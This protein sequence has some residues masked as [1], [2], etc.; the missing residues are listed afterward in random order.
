[1]NRDLIRQSPE[2]A[3]DNPETMA[4]L[5]KDALQG[6][7]DLY[8]FDKYILDYKDMEIEPHREMCDRVQYGWKTPNN[9]DGK[10]KKLLLEPRGS[11]KSS[12]VTVG[13]SLQNVVL[14]PDI[15]ILIASEKLSNAQKF[16]GEIKGHIERNEY[17]RL[18][19]GIMDSNKDDAVW[20]SNEIVVSTRK[21]NKK[22]PTIST[23][24]VEVTKVGMHY[25][26]IIVDDPVS[27]S[28]VTSKEQIDKVFAWYRLLLSMLDP[29]G[30]LI[31]IGTRWDYGDLYGTLQEYPHCEMFDILIRKAE[32]EET[33]E[34][35]GETE[36]KYLF[37]TRL[38]REFLDETKRSQGTY[39]YSCQYLNEPVADEDATFREEWFK[40]YIE[41]DLRHIDMTKFMTVDPAISLEKA[42]D[43]TA[44]VICGVDRENNIYILHIDRGHY[45][46][47]ELIKKIF[48]Y[49]ARYGLEAVGVEMNVFQ[50]TLKYQIND[51]MRAKKMFI[52]LIELK[53]NKTQAKEDRIRALQPRYEQGTIYHRKN[54]PLIG[55]LE[56]ELLRFPKGKHDDIADAEA[57]LLEIIY[58]PKPYTE[59][60]E[61]DKPKYINKITRW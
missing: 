39:I 25:D 16:L 57:S 38:T 15:R 55:E 11:F 34:K 18:L 9:P 42:A 23:A 26:L 33:N 24:G 41:E 3:L 5:Q 50:K 48:E 49:Y 32:W 40:Y 21:V 61:K 17:F 36:T 8:H 4:L 14:N 59:D 46:P 30:R 44:F 7:K 54:D 43:F 29:G 12:V 56:F 53:N 47:A 58:E 35:T 52:N 28:N 22:E 2:A 6:L 13:Y 10:N 37:P 27:Q 20:N 1:M 31:I 45:Q 19:Y 60:D 51:E